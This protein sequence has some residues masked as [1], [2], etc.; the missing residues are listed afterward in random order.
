MSQIKLKRGYKEHLPSSLP[1]GEPAFC[2]DTQE[3]Y[4]GQ[5][6]GKPLIKVNAQ[7]FNKIDSKFKQTNAQLSQRVS[8]G[9]TG[10]ITNAMLSQEVKEAMTGG[11]VA[12]VGK[13]A[14]LN[15]NLTIDCIEYYNSNFIETGDNM[16]NLNTSTPNKYLSSGKPVDNQNGWAVSDFI[17]VDRGESYTASAVDYSYFYNENKEV[18]SQITSNPFTVPDGVSYIRLSI[19]NNNPNFMLNKGTVLKTFK[20][21]GLKFKEPNPVTE[22]EDNTIDNKHLKEQSVNAENCNFFIFSDNLINKKNVL[23]D[24]TI[25]IHNGS[26]KTAKDYFSTPFINVEKNTS[27]SLLPIDA[28]FVNIYE[29]DENK[30]FIRYAVNSTGLITTSE[31]CAYVRVT[32]YSLTRKEGLCL[33]KSN[34]LMPF[35]DGVPKLDIENLDI[36]QLRINLGG[37]DEN[38]TRTKTKNLFNENEVIYDKY[39]SNGNVVDNSNGWKV[40][41]LI[42]V[43]SGVSYTL[44]RDFELANVQY[45]YFYDENKNKISQISGNPFTT[46]ANCKYVRFSIQ[47]SVDLMLFEKGSEIGYY[48]P[49]GYEDEY[50]ELLNSPLLGKKYCCI[51]DSITDRSAYP[52]ILARATGMVLIYDNGRAGTT[53]SMFRENAMSSDERINLIPLETEV[54]TIM[55]GS[56]DWGAYSIKLGESSDCAI[57]DLTEN[58]KTLT[59][60]GAYKLMLNKIYNRVPNA[61]VIILE[62]PFRANMTPTKEGKVLDDFRKATRDIAYEYGY[63]V[64]KTYTNAFINQMNYTNFLRDVVHP[65]D[66]GAEHLANVCIA[67]F[68]NIYFNF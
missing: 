39:L 20:K 25:D 21:F 42:E 46:P 4:V 50:E 24:R 67:E 28:N 23:N 12:V 41:E 19:R 29:Y 56:N 2:L 13:N 57:G 37:S 43:E 58:D 32:V 9:E 36:D 52:R 61:Y 5:G 18:V 17:K 64:V 59:F 15:E 34:E 60:W 68:K 38:S 55:G 7:D 65:N 63:P 22:I 35:V 30:K 14:I 3:M 49:Y 62:Q 33:I 10:V 31:N 27:Y 66:Y 11:S 51:G 48:V 45:S 8:K 53:V 54:I 40:S 44:S 47:N 6:K 26:E 16:Y 1:L